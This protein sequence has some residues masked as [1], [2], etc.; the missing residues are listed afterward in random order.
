[1]PNQS[2]HNCVSCKHLTPLNCSLRNEEIDIPH[3]TTCCN[4]NVET[5]T[6]LGVKYALSREVINKVVSY[7]NLPYLNGWRADTFRNG[8]NDSHV[9]LINNDLPQITFKNTNTYLDFYKNE[10]K[11][12]KNYVLG[13]V[14]GDMIGSVF[15]FHN[16]KST[17]FHLFGEKTT[18]SDDSVLTMATM[19]VILNNTL[20]ENS[21][22]AFGRRYTNRGY[23]GNFLYWIYMDE[24]EPYQSLG[25]GS[26]M[27]VSPIG[28]AY[29][30]I[31][32]VLKQAKRSAEVSHNHPEGIKGAQATASAIFLARTGKTKTEIKDFVEVMFDYD[33]D[34]TIDEMRPGYSFD[35]TCPGSVPEAIIAFLESTDYESTIR[36]AISLGGDSDTIACIAGSIAEAYYDEIPEYII[37][38]ALSLLPKEFIGLIAAFSSKYRPEK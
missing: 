31:D 23:G 37:D 4:W 33:L 19:D 25:N 11:K 32:E 3:F 21:Y 2:T 6:P 13:A 12:R 38:K 27:R 14:I 16:Y 36:L 17:D 9:V 22:Q 1:M 18:F 34:R 29:N 35:V 30:T 26:A 7:I 5:N 10:Q 28:W 8:N 15:E 24:P 20:Y